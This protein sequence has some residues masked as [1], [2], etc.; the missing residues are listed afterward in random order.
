MPEMDGMA[1]AEAVNT[2]LTLDTRLVLLTD[3][4]RASARRDVAVPE[5]CASVS[6]PV[7]ARK[8]LAAL[9]LAVGLD[10]VNEISPATEQAE[11]LASEPAVGRVLLAEDN[12]I[13]QKVAAA[14]LAS[15]GYQVDMVP[16]GVQAV[17]A[18]ATGLYDAIL[19]DCQMPRLD[20]FAATAAIRAE[21]GRQRHTPII[22]LTA[23]AQR[24][25]RERCLEAGM[26]AYLTKP[27]SKPALLAKVGGLLSSGRPVPSRPSSAAVH[28]QLVEA[29]IDLAAFNDLHV[30]GEAADVDF[31]P[32]LLE[33]FAADAELKLAELKEA[34]HTGDTPAVSRIT[35]SL[36]GS[37]GQ[38]GAVRFASSCRRLAEMALARPTDCG[39]ALSEVETSYREFCQ[40]WTKQVS[41]AGP[42]LPCHPCRAGE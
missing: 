42:T 41:M 24:Q 20:G 28:N 22:A 30:L 31:L 35:H 15:A 13:N 32:Q 29:T 3:Q 38:L 40:A 6:K 4:G 8:L 10:V 36:K 21:E 5:I 1:L 14:M 23:G 19:M 16:D 37:G 33:Q 26:D 7:E 18:A 34:V 17:Q 27:V 2:D 9:R 25:D 39:A 11:F 12:L